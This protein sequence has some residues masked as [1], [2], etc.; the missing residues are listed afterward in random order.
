MNV[1]E[2]LKLNIQQFFNRN[3]K[4]LEKPSNVSRPEQAEETTLFIEDLTPMRPK[5]N[6]GILVSNVSRLSLLPCLYLF[7][8]FGT[9][10]VLMIYKF[11]QNIVFENDILVGE[12]KV[13]N[14]FN[15]YRINPFVYHL[16]TCSN[17]IIGII[18]VFL[19]YTVLKQRFQVPEFKDHTFKLGIMLVNGMLFNLLQLGMGFI[20]YVDNYKSANELMAKEIKIDLT[21]LLFLSMIFFSILFGIYSLIALN[22]I[23][24]KTIKNKQNENWFAYKAITL[25]YLCF[26]TIVYLVVLMHSQNVINI[27]LNPNSL[28]KHYNYILALF[29]YFI[30]I[31]NG[32]LIFSFYFELKF[33]NLTLTENLEVDY[34]F[35]ESNKNVL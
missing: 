10:V 23:K 29:P 20:P 14:Y 4:G 1:F 16:Y 32:I 5:E 30:H 21:Q 6:K 24:S 13:T 2:E 12:A 35:E 27:G 18:L 17:S 25:I 26:F 11:L 15:L 31:L 3:K 22:L 19:L 28:T 7:I 9:L 34:L 8:N 33:V